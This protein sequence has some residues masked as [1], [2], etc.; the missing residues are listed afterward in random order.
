MAKAKINPMI[1][2]LHGTL[3][4]LVFRRTRNGETIMSRKPD[5]SNVKPSEAQQAHRQRFK[6]AVAYAKAALA[7]P[8]VREQY[9]KA[10]LQ[11]GKRPRDL[12]ISDFFKG[13]NLMEK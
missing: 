11:Q 13:I 8:Q 10:A 6:E 2:E 12:A 9:E 3:G 4:D 7:H 1:K 5:M